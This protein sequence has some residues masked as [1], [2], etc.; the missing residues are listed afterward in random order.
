MAW[1]RAG[2]PDWV[3]RRPRRLSPRS[4]PAPT[5]PCPPSRG[6]NGGLV[7]R[8]TPSS[9]LHRRRNPWLDRRVLN[10]AHQGGAREGP[11][12]T[13][14]AMRCA[15]ES[16]AHAIELDVHA[17][18]DGHIVVCH[19]P[20]VDRT[21][22][23][24]GAIADLTLEQVQSLDNA[25]W[26]VP[27][28][29]VAP[30]RA[31]DEY[32]LRG[33]APD[34]L[35]LR[36]PTLHEVLDAFPGVFLNFDIKQTAPAVK[37]YEEEVARVLAEHGRSDDVIVASFLDGATDA[38]RQIAPETCVSFGMEGTRAFFTAVRDGADP[39]DTPHVALQVPPWAGE[40][41]LVTAGFVD[42]AH[43]AGVAVHVWTIDEEAEMRRLVGLGVDGIM[44]DRPS[45]LAGVLDELG[46]G[47][48]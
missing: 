24:S 7:P 26:W 48:L 29:V 6:N 25:Y 20:T 1:T 35:S 18:K 31:E 43:A 44:T 12:S 39:P 42:A 4:A 11:S 9:S 17:T 14:W 27:G 28:E 16:G 21:T 34:D 33:R 47:F 10:W 2:V 19:D 45:V 40:I 3:A 23:S 15:V 5:H 38:F 22:Q 46:A 13:L 37:P 30:G 8:P 32:P 36:I 41:E